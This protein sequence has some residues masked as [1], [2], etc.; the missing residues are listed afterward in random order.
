MKTQ[1]RKI[2]YFKNEIERLK[3]DLSLLGNHLKLHKKDL[4]GIRRIKSISARINSC[5]RRLKIHQQKLL[6]SK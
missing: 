5:E 4:V 2:K 6:L 3:R 1:E